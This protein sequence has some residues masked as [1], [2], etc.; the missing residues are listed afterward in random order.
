MSVSEERVQDLP[1][2]SNLERHQCVFAFMVERFI[3]DFASN[4]LFDLK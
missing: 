2:T 1:S 3:I 4:S